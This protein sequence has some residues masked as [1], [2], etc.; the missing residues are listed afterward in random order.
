VA[1]G[2]CIIQKQQTFP[3]PHRSGLRKNTSL[4]RGMGD[5]V[6]RVAGDEAVADVSI[7]AHH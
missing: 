3:Q 4:A 5:L 2:E 1:C 7:S 6:E